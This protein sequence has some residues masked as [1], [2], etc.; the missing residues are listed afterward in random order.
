[1]KTIAIN[2]VKGGT[3]KTTLAVLLINALTNAGYRCLGIDADAS[4]NSLSAY[5]D[6]NEPAG[7]SKTVFNLFMGEK[8]ADCVMPIRDNLDLV[9]GDVRLN[10][11]RSTDSMKRLKRT[12]QG[13][14]YDFCIIDTSPT[15]DNI[16]GNVFTASDILLI[17]VEQDTFSYHAVKYQFEKLFDLELDGLDTYIILNRFERPLTDNHEAYRHQITNL[18]LEDDVLKP[19]INPNHISRSSVFRKYIN[20]RNYRIDS[21][22]ETQKAYGEIKALIQSIL[23]IEVKEA[24]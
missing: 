15:Y 24:F 22:A 10:E 21:K 14:A 23:G 17:P 20:K 19:F 2:S 3:G 5:F 7:Q 9:C 8:P 11:F 4:N 6:N 1:M 13:L 18:F 12:L 16:I